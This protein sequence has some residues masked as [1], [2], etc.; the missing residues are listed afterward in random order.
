MKLP[1]II[2]CAALVAVVIGQAVSRSLHLSNPGMKTDSLPTSHHLHPRAVEIQVEWDK[3][4]CKGSKL[5]MAMIKP[6]SQA[7]HFLTPIRSS[8]DGDLTTA[9]QTWG[10]RELPNHCD[11]LC[12]FSSDQHHLARAF[13]DLGIDTRSAGNGGPNTCHHIEHQYG[14]TVERDSSGQWPPPDNQWY[15]ARGRRLR[16]RQIPHTLLSSS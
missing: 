13:Q 8:W 7:S 11:G 10:Y 12:D 5:S 4:W 1:I 16:V 14:P 3:A 6:E 9:F 15:T 2:A